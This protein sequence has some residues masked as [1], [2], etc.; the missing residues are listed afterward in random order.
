MGGAR[1]GGKKSR[2]SGR[3]LKEKTQH[4]ILIQ[5]WLTAYGT[6]F[7]RRVVGAPSAQTRVSTS[8]RSVLGSLVKAD[9]AL[10]ITLALFLI[11]V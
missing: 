1:K 9:D 10:I 11:G 5:Q 7:K 8:N 3:N 6:V 4:A 2:Q